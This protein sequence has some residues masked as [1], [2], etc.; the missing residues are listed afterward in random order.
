MLKET[1]IDCLQ[2]ITNP[3]CEECYIKQI[4]AWLKGI[5]MTALPRAFIMNQIRKKLYY[6]G[7]NENECIICGNMVHVCSY[8]FFKKVSKVFENLQLC[9]EFVQTFLASFSYVEG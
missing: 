7:L 4:D 8:C 1:C 3:V 2:P 5:E 9:D 6:D